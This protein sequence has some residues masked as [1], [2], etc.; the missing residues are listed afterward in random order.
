MQSAM[1]LL[2]LAED[3]ELIEGNWHHGLVFNKGNVQP[4]S[5]ARLPFVNGECIGHV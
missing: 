5:I 2:I 3:R 4:K 1:A